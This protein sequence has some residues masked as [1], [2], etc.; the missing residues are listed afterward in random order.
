MEKLTEAQCRATIE[1]KDVPDD[2][3][4]RNAKV[5]VVFTQSWCGDWMIMRRYL[6][7]IEPDEAA[8]FYVEYDKEPFFEEF[9][10]FKE[11]V[12][13]SNQVPYIRF[14]RDGKFI[15]ERN[16]IFSKRRFLKKFG[17]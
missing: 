8:V 3:T 2:I 17:R 14:Y 11:T 7:K 13:E 1:S 15:T 4:S 6:K 12:F 16:S 10:T 5:A 9:R